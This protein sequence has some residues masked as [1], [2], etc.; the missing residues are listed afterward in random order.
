LGIAGEKGKDMYVT[1]SWWVLRFFGEREV[2]CGESSWNEM[3][4]RGWLYIGHTT[5]NSMVSECGSCR[6]SDVATTYWHARLS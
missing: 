6:T 2:G 5:S 1:S 3:K 4:G